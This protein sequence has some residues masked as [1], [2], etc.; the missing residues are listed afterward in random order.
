MATSDKYDRQ[1]RLWGASGQKA[2]SESTVMLIGATAVGTETLKNLVLPGVG[3]IVVVDDAMVSLEDLQSNFFVTME[4]NGTNGDTASEPTCR[5]KV[6]L[7]LLQELNPDVNGFYQHV[8]DLNEVDFAQL[9]ASYKNLLVIGADLEP[10]VLD[11]VAQVC[12]HSVP[13]IQVQSYGLLGLVRIQT[14]HPLCIFDPKPTSS[15]P[16]LRLLSPPQQFI[17]FC[18]S[19]QIDSFSMDDHQHSHIPYPVILY[20]SQQQWKEANQGKLPETFAQKQQF[21]ECIKRMARKWDMQVNFHEAYNNAY[22]AYTEKTL[23]SHHLESLLQK[24]QTSSPAAAIKKS[25]ATSQA[26][27]KALIKF[28]QNHNSRAPFSGTLPDMTATTQSYVQLQQIYHDQAHKDAMELKMYM[29]EHDRSVPMPSDEEVVRFCTNVFD[30]DVVVFRS[31]HDE[32]VLPPPQDLVDE[33]QCIE[34]FEVPEL[35]PFLWYIGLRACRLFHQQ[36]GCYP[37][38][39][40]DWESDVPLLQEKILQVCRDLQLTDCDWIQQSLLCGS[41][42]QDDDNDYDH[43]EEETMLT[44]I[45]TELAR[46]GNAEIHNI[47]SIVGGVASQEAVKIITGQYTPLNNTFIYNGIASVGGTYQ[48]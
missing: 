12:S 38:V 16:D 22:L 43:E 27:L 30:L 36:Q 48:F 24:M 45:A 8:S 10:H 31:C 2:L 18:N 7:E 3:N 32:Y 44:K 20:K 37:G 25:M 42:N 9:I 46:Q 41:G 28:V 17:D 14:P 21:K 34:P 33:W 39:T 35:T 6:S 40:S 29:R 23:D 5:A 19:I 47:A 26:L 4:I 13:F 11:K 15:T 1:L